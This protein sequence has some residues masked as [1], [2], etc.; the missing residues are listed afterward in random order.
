[1]KCYFVF[2]QGKLINKNGKAMHTYESKFADMLETNPVDQTDSFYELFESS[3][4]YDQGE[5]I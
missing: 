2:K 4:T 5:L 3:N 1:M